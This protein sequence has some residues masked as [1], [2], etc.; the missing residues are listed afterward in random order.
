MVGGRYQEI[1]GELSHLFGDTNAVQAGMG[2][3]QPT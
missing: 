1:L 2:G 3:E